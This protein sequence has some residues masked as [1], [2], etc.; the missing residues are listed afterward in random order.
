MDLVYTIAIILFTVVILVAVH[1]FGHF[2]VARRCGVHVLRFCIGFGPTLLMARR[3]NAT[4]RLRFS[5]GRAL[6]GRHDQYATEYVIAAIP[7]GGYVKMLDGREGEIPPGMEA[8]AF[9]RKPVLQ[10]MAVVVAGPLANLLLAVLAYWFVYLSGESGIAP[11][12]GT[13][14]PGSV[15]ELAGVEPGQEI[16]AVDGRP[17]PTWQAVNFH[18]L[19]RIGDSGVIS[20]DLRYPNSDVVYQSQAHLEQWMSD[21][22]EPN[23]VRGLGIEMWRPPVPVVLAEVVPDSPAAAAGLQAGDRV[24]SADGQAMPDWRDWVQHVRARPGQRIGIEIERAG[25]LVSGAITPAREVAADGSEYGR[26]GVTVA[27]PEWPQHMMREFHYG[28]VAAIVAATRRTG[29]L[30][31]FTLGAVKKM[32]VGLI[33]PKNLSGPITIA[34]VADDSARSGLKSFVTLLALLS[35]TLGVVNLLPI[36]VLDGGHLLFL[37]IEWLLGRPLPEKVYMLANQ[38]GLFIIVGVMMLALYNDVVRL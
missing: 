8:S 37:T 7:L 4:R 20:F 30:V 5:F 13:V 22:T 38:M 33:S 9:N 35:V 31:M 15:A 3:S 11:V 21:A 19:D 32:L 18:L 24:L 2:W 6:P 23:L 1:E 29:E 10:R 16:V 27:I 12:V 25:R 17:T 34:K 28:P 36:P 14:A 26:V